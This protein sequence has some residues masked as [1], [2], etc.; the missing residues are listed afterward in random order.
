MN[1]KEGGDWLREEASDPDVWGIWVTREQA[2]QV[3][4]AIDE[5]QAERDRL[6]KLKEFTQALVGRCRVIGLAGKDAI[7]DAMMQCAL[8]PD[9]IPDYDTLKQS[10]DRL[11]ELARDALD[12][13]ESC[14]NVVTATGIDAV[15]L[16]GY[17]RTAIEKARGA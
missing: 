5:L 10:H 9:Q 4:D 16:R 7:D 1:A 8:H 14:P 13:A 11:L 6:H 2:R 12:F 17:L 15:R 3:A